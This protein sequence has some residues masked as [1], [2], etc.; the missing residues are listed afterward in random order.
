MFRM[1]KRFLVIAA[2]GYIALGVFFVAQTYAFGTYE[3]IGPS[4][5]TSPL[6]HV[7]TGSAD[8][9]VNAYY[10]YL[11]LRHLQQQTE[12]YRVNPVD[13]VIVYGILGA[14]LV[15]FSTLG[16]MWYSREKRQ[17]IYPVEIYNGYIAEG[18]G[19][20]DLF[21]WANYATML[22]FMVFYIWWNL[23]FGQWY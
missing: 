6:T 3:R 10:D 16:F 19:R 13:I 12:T 8:T 1:A 17:G 23:T 18:T 14:V 15:I 22:A 7:P 11:Q 9:T 5:Q 2:V 4:F 21:T 20:V